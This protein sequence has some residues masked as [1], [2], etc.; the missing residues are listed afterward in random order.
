MVA[1]KLGKRRLRIEALEN[2]LVLSVVTPVSTTSTNWSGYAVET[3][4]TSPKTGAVT[5]V[6]GVWNVPT[7][8]PT[9]SKSTAYCSVWVGIDGYSSSTVEQIG[10][11]SDVVN[12]KTQYYAWYEMYPSAS[13]NITSMT[14]S[15]GDSIS[16]SVQYITSG[17]HSGQFCLT[18][19][20]T[21]RANDS[22]S[23]YQTL[24]SAKRSSAEWIV[25]APSSYSGV[26]PLAQFSTVTFSNATATINGTATAIDSSPWQSAKIN[27][28]SRTTTE[29]TTSSLKDSGTTSSFTVTYNT[30]A[31]TTTPS[32][33]RGWFTSDWFTPLTSGIGGDNLAWAGYRSQLQANQSAKAADHVFAS[34]SLLSPFDGV[35]LKDLLSDLV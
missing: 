23:I 8:T 13:K 29:D 3:S 15:A 24:A 19:T 27:M 25:E 20:D 14:I 22:F 30:A 7:V 6:S 1:K 2:R 33:Q 18:I 28:V 16:A 32:P 5:S 31:A 17:T 34:S 35:A 12:G 21:S 26:L 9:S 4:L 10:T 11:D